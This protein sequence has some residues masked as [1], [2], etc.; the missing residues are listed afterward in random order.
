MKRP[1]LTKIRRFAAQ[2]SR[3]YFSSPPPPPLP[4]LVFRDRVSLYS[5]G[6][7]GTHAVDHAGLELINPPASAS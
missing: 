5:S 6:C 2:R 4:L 7:P 1:K 3:K